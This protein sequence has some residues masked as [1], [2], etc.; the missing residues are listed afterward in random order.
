MSAAGQNTAV[1]F[2]SR[3]ADN[4]ERARVQAWDLGRPIEHP[5]SASLTPRMAK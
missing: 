2:G 5:V 4:L 1:E 3:A